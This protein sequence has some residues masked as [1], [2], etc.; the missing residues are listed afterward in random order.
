MTSVKVEA[1]VTEWVNNGQHN[2]D[3]PDNQQPAA[4]TAANYV[5]PAPNAYT[6]KGTID[7]VDGNAVTYTPGAGATQV[8]MMN[9]MARFLG[10]LHRAAGVKEI[11]YSSTKYTWNP[12]V[13]MEIS[14]TSPTGETVDPN[15]TELVGSNW[16]SNAT[17]PTTLVHDIVAAASSLTTPLT[18]KADGETITINFPTQP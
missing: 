17:P 7:V 12:A 8:D 3:L 1:T 10:A 5:Y 2:V 15:K 18:L 13:A 9:D 11:E 14:R 16:V 4:V 6:Y